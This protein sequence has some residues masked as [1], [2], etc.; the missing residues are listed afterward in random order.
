WESGSRQRPVRRFLPTHF[1]RYGLIGPLCIA[2]PQQQQ[3]AEGKFRLDP[4]YGDFRPFPKPGA[5]PASLPRLA[6]YPWRDEGEYGMVD[7][8]GDERGCIVFL[9]REFAESKELNF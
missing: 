1:F 4:D 9:F 8:G 5:G 6:V 7:G 3:P 2:R